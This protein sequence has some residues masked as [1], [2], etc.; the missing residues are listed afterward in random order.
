MK[1]LNVTK[2]IFGGVLLYIVTVSPGPGNDIWVLLTSEN[3]VMSLYF[4][5][6]VSL[7][8]NSLK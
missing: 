2:Y 3:L 8:F 5:V 1:F 7:G 6:E 4:I